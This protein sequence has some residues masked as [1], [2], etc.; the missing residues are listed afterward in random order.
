MPVIGD[1]T[2]TRLCRWSRPTAPGGWPRA[3]WWRLLDSG[4]AA[5]AVARV[6]FATLLH[7]YGRRDDEA[8]EQAV[9]AID[10]LNRDVVLSDAFHRQSP[11]IATFLRSEPVSLTRRPRRLKPVT[12][13]RPGDL[14]AIGDGDGFRAAYVMAELPDDPQ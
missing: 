12:F 11:A 9:T 13:L 7:K 6:A 10:E 3:R 2:N 5:G 14:I 4:G 8:I 1:R